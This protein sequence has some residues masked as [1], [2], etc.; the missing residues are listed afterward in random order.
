M[1]DK[2]VEEKLAEEIA[3]KLCFEDGL[4]WG[5]LGQA[6]RYFG[7]KDQQY[8]LRVATQLL[9]IVAKYCVVED[10]NQELPKND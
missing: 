5:K 6:Q 3:I 4:N 8:Y 2:T 1:A 9:K 7:C 10:E